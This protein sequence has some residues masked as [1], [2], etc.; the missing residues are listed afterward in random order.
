MKLSSRNVVKG[1]VLK[2][3]EGMIMAKVKVEVGNG[4]VLTALISK[5]AVEE[6]D[7]KVGEDINALIKA[8]S[9]MLARD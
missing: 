1:K 5:E 6:L 9:V 3:D 8:T 7:V 2:V 4:N